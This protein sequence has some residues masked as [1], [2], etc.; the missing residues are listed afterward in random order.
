VSRDD[1]WS[2][3][4]DATRAEVREIFARHAD[5]AANRGAESEQAER[6][7][8]LPGFLLLPVRGWRSLGRRGKALVLALAAALAGLAALLLPPAF[9]NASR[10]E[11]NER[12]AI[13]ANRE[14][15]RREL[16]RDQRPHRA[17]LRAGAPLAAAL[18][19]RVAA[20]A[21]A[22]A[23]AGELDGPIGATS[24]RPLARSDVD[25][26]SPVFTC[27]VERG[28]GGVYRDRRLLL[29]YRFRGRVERS[30][31]RATWCKESPRPLHPDTEEFVTVP[32][33]RACTG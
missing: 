9:E 20:D 24:C 21:R 15:I 11:L 27:L 29:G 22:R 28:E 30:S 26:R 18:A 33:S 1:P 13:A 10:N 16:V 14:G 5:A 7:A 19:E 6:R 8:A 12:R 2:G 31:R 17:M 3:A 32:L 23:A 4:G 25:P